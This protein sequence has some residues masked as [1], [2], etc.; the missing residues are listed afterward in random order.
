M[1]SIPPASE[2]LVPPG[3]GVAGNDSVVKDV[4]GKGKAVDVDVDNTG[5]MDAMMN[6]ITNGPML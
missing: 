4:K 3:T 6:D 1:G 5:K 2:Y